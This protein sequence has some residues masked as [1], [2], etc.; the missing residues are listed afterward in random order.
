M[1]RL[2]FVAADSRLAIE[3]R[4][5][6]L[7]AKLAHDLSIKAGDLVCTAS[8][9]GDALE[10]ELRARVRGLVVEGVL[11]GKDID[12]GTLSA[13]DRSD[14]QRKIAADVLKANEVVATVRCSAPG[15]VLEPGRHDV[16]AT[17]AVALGSA[18]A[19]TRTRASVEVGDR[20]HASGR[21]AI[22]LSSLRIEPVKGPLNAFRVDDEVEVV[23]DLVFE[24]N[25]SG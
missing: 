16:S 19:E 8:I 22:K 23:Y 3:T 1:T 12:R 18:R 14:I 5:K 4:A 20:I 21:A 11:R 15:N 6:G 2:E 9:E 24:K 13:S 25:T 10:M 7:L 17:V